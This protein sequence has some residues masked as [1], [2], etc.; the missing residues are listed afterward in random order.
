MRISTW[1]YG[2]VLGVL[3]FSLGGAA[4]GELISYWAFD[5]NSNLDLSSGSQGVLTVTPQ[6]WFSH[7]SFPPP[8]SGTDINRINIGQTTYEYM[9][10]HDPASALS[11]GIVD[12]DGLDLTGYSGMK[13]SFAAYI[14]DLVSLTHYR[15][16]ICYVDD[17]EVSR[18]SFDVS[19][20]NWPLTAWA[21]TTIDLPSDIDNESDVHIELQFNNFLDVN[22]RLHIDNIQLTGVPEPATLSLL[23]LGA[24]LLIRRRRNK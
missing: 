17:S 19:E 1:R 7:V 5:D 11:T 10:I 21:L 16:A 18:Q 23:T 24:A 8:P 20:A 14:S 9:D 3:F 2:I 13:L 22:E 12:L 15:E 6:G 4:R